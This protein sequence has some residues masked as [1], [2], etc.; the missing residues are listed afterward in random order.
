MFPFEQCPDFSGAIGHRQFNHPPL[1]R[2]WVAP[3]GTKALKWQFT[4]NSSQFPIFLF[5]KATADDMVERLAG[6]RSMVWTTR[7]DVSTN[8]DHDHD[9]SSGRLN[10]QLTKDPD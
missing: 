4:T 6:L 10:P 7:P 3:N 1:L 5:A 2:E 9:N 8:D